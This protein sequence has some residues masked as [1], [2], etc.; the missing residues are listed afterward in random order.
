MAPQDWRNGDRSR[1]PQI[2]FDPATVL[3]RDASLYP[4]PNSTGT[5]TLCDALGFFGAG[6][7]HSEGA[8]WQ[9]DNDRNANHGLAAWDAR[10]NLT[11]SSN[12]EPPFG[13][14]RKYGSSMNR[15]VDTV[16]GGW[17]VGYVSK[18]VP[19]FPS[20]LPRLARAS[21]PCAALSVRTFS[22]RWLRI[23]GPFRSGS[24]PALPPLKRPRCRQRNLR[25]PA[26]YLGNV[27]K[28]FHRNRTRAGLLQRGCFGQ[29][30]LPHQGR[31]QPCEFDNVLAP[32]A[33]SLLAQH[34]RP[35]FGPGE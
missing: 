32:Q 26:S 21:S 18:A 2:I 28:H 25:L 5:R 11:F 17:S 1:L 3:F 6:G 23:T 12:M 20:R 9:N 16:L 14:G 30:A 27:R 22:G 33:G 8:Y 19:A 4:L 31:L 13:K 15:A 29:Q 10:Q 35:Y 24:V 7:V 34:L